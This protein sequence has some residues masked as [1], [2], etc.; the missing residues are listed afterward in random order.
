MY[1]YLHVLH[2]LDDSGFSYEHLSELPSERSDLLTDQHSE[3]I[4]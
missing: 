4:F 2:V 1:V 3:L